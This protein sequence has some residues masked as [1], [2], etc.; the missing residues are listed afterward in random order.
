[1]PSATRPA[2]IIS[3]RGFVR[4]GASAMGSSWSEECT[5]VPTV[6][7]GLPSVPRAPRV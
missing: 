1:M 7:D 4:I 3:F 5:A 6:H 2:F